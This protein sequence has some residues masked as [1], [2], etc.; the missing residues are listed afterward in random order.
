VGVGV[1]G[2]VGVVEG[3]RSGVTYPACRL[4]GLRDRA[5]GRM[6]WTD[7]GLRSRG[8]VLCWWG[9]GGP[10]EVCGRRGRRV[11]RGVRSKTLGSLGRG[12]VVA[13]V[14]LDEPD[15]DCCAWAVLVVGGVAGTED[16]DG[17]G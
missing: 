8:W 6:G 4:G 14:G 7:N 11:R 12:A 13:I 1:L 15:V 17:P 5:S 9:G 2:E 16:C 10:P 3:L